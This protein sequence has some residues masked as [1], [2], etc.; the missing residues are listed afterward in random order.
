MLRTRV[1]TAVVLAPIALALVLTLPA[2]GLRLFV[3]AVLLVGSWEFRALADL[4]RSA[5][6]LLV[7]LQAAMLLTMT[8]LWPALSQHASLILIAG[9]LAWCVMFLRLATYR[10][11]QVADKGYR[12]VGFISAL[13]SVSFAWFSIAWLRD[14]P[15]GQYLILLLLII[16]WAAD[17][18]AY[19][20]GRSLGRRK[21]AVHISPGKTWEG[22][23]GGLV[24]SSVLAL[25]VAAYTGWAAGSLAG[26]LAVFLV[27]ILASA[28]GDLFISLHK[29][30]VGIKDTGKLFPG[31]GGV[32]DRLDSLI[33][34]APFLALGLY[35][36]QA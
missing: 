15:S 19:F 35:L 13:A 3:G 9:C 25:G 22:L 30:T 32:F 17:V 28:A 23:A 4:Q 7:A 6:L 2:W 36:L 8:T 12:L 18:G 20:T 27:T 31:H 29:R 33:A 1:L 16:I 24:L 21:L 26:L 14:Q 5:G 34:G 10:D 11:G